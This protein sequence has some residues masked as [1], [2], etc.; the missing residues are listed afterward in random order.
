MAERINYDL[1]LLDLVRL[2]GFDSPERYVKTPEQPMPAE[3]QEQTMQPPDPFA[4][5]EQQLY[6]MGGRPLQQA[7]KTD[8]QVGGMAGLM[9]KYFGQ[10][11]PPEISDA[12]V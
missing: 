7:V 4:E 9:D 2:F 3:G 6:E 10:Q 12:P 8:M 5:T 1:V 11:T